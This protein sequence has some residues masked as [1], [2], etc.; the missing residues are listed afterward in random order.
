M[1][2]I[3][4]GR[5]QLTSLVR[6]LTVHCMVSEVLRSWFTNTSV[7]SFC[8]KGCTRIFFGFQAKSLLY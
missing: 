3:R 1:M 8:A 7:R 4:A 2:L 6:R 5:A